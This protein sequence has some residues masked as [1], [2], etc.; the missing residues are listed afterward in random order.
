MH[1]IQIGR[2]H[3]TRCLEHIQSTWSSSVLNKVHWQPVRN[4]TT[5]LSSPPSKSSSP[6]WCTNSYS[7]WD[8]S[9]DVREFLVTSS[10]SQFVNS[11]F[12]MIQSCKIGNGCWMPRY[13]RKKLTKSTKMSTKC[14][15]E[16]VNIFIWFNYLL[17]FYRQPFVLVQKMMQSSCNKK[18]PV[19]HY[20]KSV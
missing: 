13:L 15:L 16:H 12:C 18:V 20:G 14:I 2:W 3:F 5:T 19:V 4:T 11:G 10:L 8:L 1:Q 6:F 17:S 9:F 7:T